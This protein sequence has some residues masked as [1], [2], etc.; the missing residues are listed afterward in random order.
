MSGGICMAQL[1]KV[2]VNTGEVTYLID[3]PRIYTS[4]AVS[5]DERSVAGADIAL[6]LNL[7]A[8]PSSPFISR[9]SY[10]SSH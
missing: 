6:T 8:R 4:Y 9:Q 2:D 1:V 5:P 7:L 3:E 10:N